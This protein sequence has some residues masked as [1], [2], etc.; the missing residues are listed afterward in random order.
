MK[1]HKPSIFLRY[2]ISLVVMLVLLG[3][4]TGV[5]VLQHQTQTSAHGIQ[6]QHNFTMELTHPQ[7]WMG[8][9]A[10]LGMQLPCQAA[11]AMQRCYTPQQIQTAYHASPLYKQGITGKGRSIVIVDAFQSPTIRHDLRMFDRIFG[12][13][14]PFLH[15]YAPDGLVPFNQQD[16]T[17]VSWAAEIT[18]DVEW[19]H[20]I[21]PEATI[22]LVLAN[23]L[24]GNTKG[25]SGFL[26]NIL[27]ATNFAIKNNLGDVI[28]QSFGGNESCATQEVL[29]Q[30]HTVFQAAAAK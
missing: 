11:T 24:K 18:L 7:Y 25:L 14:D 8:G 15:I 28:S 23:P 16:P 29:Q 22:N 2:T 26:Q 6:A 10:T 27:R 19:A 13:P 4:A 17:Q 5:L 12:L 1:Q 9:N 30:Q 20:A 3:M 21:A